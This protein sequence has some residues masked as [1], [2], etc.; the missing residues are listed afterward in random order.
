MVVRSSV[1]VPLTTGEAF[2]LFTEQMATWWPLSGYS[3][4]EDAATGI[5]VEPR[6]GGR[7]YET[8]DDGRTADWGIISDWEPGERFAMSWHPGNEPK[9]ATKIDIRFTATA[10]GGTLVDVVHAGWEIRG[11]DA[12]KLMAG[13][14]AGWKR[15]LGHYA[16]AA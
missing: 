4:Y 6:A 13:Y 1:T 8:T 14:D 16:A 9:L 11:A 3:V 7:V 15:V 2:R 10:D 12:A 5:V